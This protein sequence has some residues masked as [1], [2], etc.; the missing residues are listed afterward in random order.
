MKSGKYTLVTYLP[1]AGMVYGAVAV[2]GKNERDR[3]VLQLF[4]RLGFVRTGET[5]ARI[6]AVGR[7]RVQEALVG[8]F[9]V[10]AEPA[11]AGLMASGDQTAFEAAVQE[12]TPW[13][14][15]RAMDPRIFAELF[16]V[17]VEARHRWYSHPRVPHS[18]QDHSDLAKAIDRYLE[19]QSDWGR[20]LFELVHGGTPLGEEEEGEEEEEEEE[21]E[22][23]KDD[24]EM[25]EDEKEEVMGDAQAVDDDEDDAM[26]MD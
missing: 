13:A 12:R 10:A 8:V 17:L 3:A 19:Q 5:D 9:T 7:R 1:K 23:M 26:D 21:E 24:E 4:K 11:V 6:R 20:Q 22:E 14:R 25:E 2:L 15:D 18:F 16:A